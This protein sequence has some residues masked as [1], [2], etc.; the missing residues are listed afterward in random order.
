MYFISLKENRPM[1]I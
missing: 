1:T